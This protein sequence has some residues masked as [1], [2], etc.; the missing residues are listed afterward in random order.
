MSDFTSSRTARNAADAATANL[1]DD[2]GRIV[3]QS[4]ADP[5]ACYIKDGTQAATVANGPLGVIVRAENELGGLVT[6]SYRG[7]SVGRA[8]A[9]GIAAGT[10]L[11]GIDAAG[12]LIAY[13]LPAAGT[14]T[15]IAGSLAPCESGST[16][17]AAGDAFV[18]DFNPQLAQG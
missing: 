3:M 7:P 15:W 4:A 13:A 1:T 17:I 18:F 10:V 12:D 5:L 8:G 2:Y 16:A 11:L 6:F 9:A 14:N